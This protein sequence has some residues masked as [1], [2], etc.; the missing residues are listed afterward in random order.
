M[1]VLQQPSFCVY[2]S[3]SSVF[4]AFYLRKKVEYLN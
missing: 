1:K 4:V 2:G 3:F